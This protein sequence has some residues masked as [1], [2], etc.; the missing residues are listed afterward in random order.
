MARR[1]RAARAS[2]SSCS[3]VVLDDQPEQARALLSDL[4]GVEV[5]H[6]QDLG[7]EH[8]LSADLVLVDHQLD[9]KEWP[10]R[11]SQP[12]ACRPM[13]GVALAGIIRGHLET[14]MP[15]GRRAA[16]ALLSGQLN[17]LTPGLDA[18]P[19]HVAAR[20]CG[21]DWAFDKNGTTLAPLSKRIAALADGVRRIPDAWDDDLGADAVRKSV[22]GLLGLGETRWHALALA[23]AERSHPPIHQLAAWSDGVAFVRWL[24]QSI[25]AYPTFLVGAH[26][27]AARLGVRPS[28]LAPHLGPNRALEK[29]LRPARYRGLLHDFLGDR[30]WLAGLDEII[31]KE[32]AGTVLE[33]DVIMRWLRRRTRTEP[34]ALDDASTLVVD[35]RFEFTGE[36][37]P[38]SECVEVWPDDWPPYADKPWTTVKRAKDVPRLGAVVA[39]SGLSRL[40]A[41]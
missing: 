37:A 39:P 32:S 3:I 28:W 19:E 36:V 1:R 26:H 21:L 34:E 41:T 27:V 17:R 38:F 9:D 25:L 35:E 11:A 7:Q 14:Q 13:N 18:P 30:W 6:P 23:Q 4:V 29:L 31:W 12:L 16:V 10:A 5:L 20:A 33:R 22:R 2:R 8:L 40:G 24:A 15:S